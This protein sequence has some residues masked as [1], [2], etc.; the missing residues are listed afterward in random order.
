M[1]IVYYITGT[2]RGI[3]KALIHAILEGPNA[4]ETLRVYGLA[5]GAQDAKNAKF[6]AVKVWMCRT[7]ARF[8][9]HTMHVLTYTYP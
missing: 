2:S 6:T 1:S 5:R 4:S 8:P 3:G 7:Y 9:T